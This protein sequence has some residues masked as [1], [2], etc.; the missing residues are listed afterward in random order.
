MAKKKQTGPIVLEMSGALRRDKEVKVAAAKTLWVPAVNN[1]GGF[2]RWGFVE[3]NDPWDAE[4]TIRLP[5]LSSSM[6]R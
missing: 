2:G 5:H 6:T 4:N 1:H 3:I